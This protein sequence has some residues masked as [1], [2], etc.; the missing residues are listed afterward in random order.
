M[1]LDHFK[2]I[3][4]RLG[5]AT[6]DQVLLHVAR[7]AQALCTPGDLFGRLGG[8][9]FAMFLT[10]QDA[11][12]ALQ[13]AG[14]LQQAIRDIE[15]TPDEAGM[16]TTASIG[17]SCARR[18]DVD[19]EYLY[20]TADEAMYRAKNAGRDRTVLASVAGDSPW[21]HSQVPAESD[22]VR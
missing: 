21:A 18:G 17:I 12:R 13:V 6:G 1:D 22:R 7:S 14:R 15:I 20:R 10:G 19:Y 11:E 5:H 3:N 8:E 2:Q 9:E 4:D 16:R